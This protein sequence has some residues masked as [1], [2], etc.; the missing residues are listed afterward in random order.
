MLFRGLPVRLA[1]RTVR[2]LLSMGLLSLL[3]AGAAACSG[4]PADVEQPI[5]VEQ[6]GG[7]A[8]AS[9]RSS[10]WQQ[11]GGDLNPFPGQPVSR[12]SLVVEPPAGQVLAFSAIDPATSAGRVFVFRRRHGD[13]APVGEALD[14]A[15][16]ALAANERGGLAVCLAPPA[17]D[18]AGGPMVRRW[19]PGGWIAVGG[20]IGAETGFAGTR[21]LVDA[22]GGIV[23][24][25]R[26]APIVAWSAQVGPKNDR[27]YAATW[28]AGDGHWT[29]LGP[30]AIG[31]R[32]DAVSL[33]AGA[34][35]RVYVAT[36]TPGGSYG[37]GATTQV[38]SW[39]GT[40]WNQLGADMPATADPV[41]GES[42]GSSVL[43]LQDAASG[44]L[45]VMRW[46][47]S[48]WSSLPSPGAGGAPALAFTSSGKPVIAFVDDAAPPAIHVVTL[49]HG[50]WRAVGGPVAAAGTGLVQLAVALDDQDRPTV[51]WSEY[52]FAAGTSAVFAAR[53][54]APLR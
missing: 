24:G 25:E 46:T 16:P 11:L 40:A 50:Q 37:G 39:D 41:I 30:G 4:E 22:C 13:W 12:P 14:G 45:R 34:H 20:D 36:F 31:V 51:A 54:D 33:A 3:F 42:H 29:G 32:P 9:C 19:T 28:R 52:D 35:D 1:R 43:A 8:R 10:G 53:H 15:G 48:G 2:R 23:L 18:A 47:D 21:Y 6:P 49:A 7:Q 38:W 17:S 26:Q 44:T 27:V 5:A